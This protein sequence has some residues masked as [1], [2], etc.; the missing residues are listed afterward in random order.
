MDPYSPKT[1]KKKKKPPFV[2]CYRERRVTVLV[3]TFY[4]SPVRRHLVFILEI[5]STST[6]LFHQT[7]V[8][9]HMNGHD[10]GL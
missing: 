4:V 10:T 8:I 9:A 2:I 5:M 7:E 3:N 1:K 6:N